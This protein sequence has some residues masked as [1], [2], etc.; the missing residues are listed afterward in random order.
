MRWPILTAW[1]ERRQ[2]AADLERQA[3]EA[4]RA[5]RRARAQ[6]PEVH[7]ARNQFAA[8]VEAALARRRHQ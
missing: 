3:A 1:R 4:A 5:A 6:W 7:R 8:E 2:R